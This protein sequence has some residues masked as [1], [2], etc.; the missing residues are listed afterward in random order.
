[1]FHAT[2]ESDGAVSVTVTGGTQPY[3]CPWTGPRRF[4]ICIRR[5]YRAVCQELLP[6]CDSSRRELR[7]FL[8]DNKAAI[9]AVG[10][11]CGDCAV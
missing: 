7:R 5:S 1:M 3:T 2:A 11:L 10:W 9:H 4:Y 8:Y 6:A